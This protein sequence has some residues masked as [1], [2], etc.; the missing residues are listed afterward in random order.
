METTGPEKVDS[1]TGSALDTVQSQNDQVD[2]NKT[3]ES[4]LHKSVTPEKD[5]DAED[6]SA[7]Q[8][9]QLTLGSFFDAKRSSDTEQQTPQIAKKTKI[10]SPTKSEDHTVS[11]PGSV[12]CT[13]S[14]DAAKTEIT[15]KSPKTYTQK[16]S[17]ENKASPV[18]LALSKSET[19]VAFPK[20]L[21]PFIT[22]APSAN[23]N[24]P[25]INVDSLLAKY[26]DRAHKL[27]EQYQSQLSNESMYMPSDM[28]PYATSSEATFPDFALPALACLVEGKKE[29]LKSLSGLVLKEME[30]M[31]PKFA[32]KLD[33][34]EEK[35][36]II[37]LR[38]NYVKGAEQFLSR[39]S[40]AI[41]NG[42]DG[43]AD[44][45]R[46]EVTTLDLF[47][48]TA[49]SMVRQARS[50]RKKTSAHLSAVV[51]LLNSLNDSKNP[52][53]TGD[54]AK[55]DAKVEQD[56]ERVHRHERDEEKQR[57]V[58]EVKRKKEQEKEAAKR[59]R[60]QQK[61]QQEEERKRRKLE[62]AQGKQR[63]KEAAAANAKRKIEAHGNKLR[64]GSQ[65]DGKQSS[66]MAF[67]ACPR[68]TLTAPTSGK[69]S[70][71]LQN[72]G[73]SESAEAPTAALVR[74]KSCPFDVRLFRAALSGSS[75]LNVE[76]TPLVTLSRNAQQSLLQST[77]RKTVDVSVTVIHDDSSEMRPYTVRKTI[78][79]RNKYKFLFFHEDLRPPY[80][81][82]WSKQSS[83]V[84]GRTPFGKDSILTYDDDSEA[85]WEEGDD[86]IGEDLEDA[87]AA[88]DDEEKDDDEGSMADDGWLAG[89]EDDLDDVGK[90]LRRQQLSKAD[91]SDYSSRTVFRVG[92]CEGCPQSRSSTRADLEGLS[93]GEAID[94]LQRH[95]IESI[96]E[97]PF[98]LD[99]FPPPIVVEEPVK[100]S[101]TP[102]NKDPSQD[103]I[104]T[105]A[106]FVHNATQLSKEKL[107]DEFRSVHPSVFS[108]RAQGV[109]LLD[110]MAAKSKACGASC[111]QVKSAVL[112]ELGLND[113]VDKNISEN[114]KEEL[115]KTMVTWLRNSDIASIC[116]RDKLVDEVRA[117]EPVFQ[118][119][120]RADC[121]RLLLMVA[122][123]TKPVG[124]GAPQWSI[125]SDIGVKF[126]GL[127]SK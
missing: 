98:S 40:D 118:S 109:R 102:V 18:C 125:K 65:D 57:V 22:P 34:V 59:K 55:L 110:G 83:I 108:G 21:T 70:A 69:T 52:D 24:Q 33:M 103:E 119:M 116:S 1:P 89:E 26:H 81:G 35:I 68:P 75:Q 93:A 64:V 99:P 48:K 43:S 86:E 53:G 7:K 23:E 127:D 9:Q 44:C 82:T 17:R 61:E 79:V 100:A 28:D 117:K 120:T 67:L 122:T 91:K 111:W 14:P 37:A 101:G 105:F 30:K 124:S 76:P 92:P 60:Q 41:K 88:D 77:Q 66:L 10:E 5:C 63:K 112:E 94:L 50:T 58:A 97:V 32:F 96:K 54:Q 3:D 80:F 29:S 121:L 51:K 31:F 15:S 11:P 126:L 25:R 71:T 49:A 45:L 114:R 20:V 107:I 16:A 13:S 62:V 27:L 2:V 78:S 87:D 39:D 95:T 56:L 73:T 90:A 8:P 19:P 115:M 72:S 106:Q 4:D 12:D 47:P 104:K 36:N 123:K 46:W 74:A 6:K 113:L 85:E 38:K 84:T 42:M